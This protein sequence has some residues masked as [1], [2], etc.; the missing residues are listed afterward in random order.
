MIIQVDPKVTSKG[1]SQNR[2]RFVLEYPEL[3]TAKPSLRGGRN[4]YPILSDF[5]NYTLNLQL[6]DIAFSLRL[7]NTFWESGDKW[8]YG[9]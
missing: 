9:K 4:F 6:I 8:N 5:L 3:V 2:G 7:G 1:N